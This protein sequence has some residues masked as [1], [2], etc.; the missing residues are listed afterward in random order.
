MCNRE[1]KPLADIHL[2]PPQPERDYCV[3]VGGRDFHF[4]GLKALLGA[5]DCSKAGDRNAH[6]A[7]ADELAREA[8]RAIL[9]DLTLGHLYEHPLLDEAGRV[10]SVMRANYD[11]DAAGFQRIAN[12]TLG[13][14]KD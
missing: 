12:W 7:A 10:D 5:A 1:L 14:L 2:P 8:A 11:L 3:R 13:D 9:S 6:L 4:P